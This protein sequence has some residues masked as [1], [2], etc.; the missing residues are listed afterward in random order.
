MG[1]RAIRYVNE[2][3]IVGIVL[4]GHPYHLDPEVNHGI[5]ELINGY[6]VAVLTEDSVAGRMSAAN[7]GDEI[8]VIDQWAYHSRL[9]RAAYAVAKDPDLRMIEMVQMNSFGCGLDAISAD[10]AAKILEK[11]GRLHTLLKIDESKNNGAVRIRIRSLLAAVKAENSLPPE[12]PVALKAR[13]SSGKRTILCPPLSQYHF[14]FLESIMRAEGYD[15]RVLPEGGRESAELGL[16]YVNNDACYPAMIVVGQFLNALRSGEYDPKN[17]DCFYAQTGGSCRA[18]NYVPLLRRALD[19]AGFEEARVLAVNSQGKNSVSFRLPPRVI[20]RSAKA[21]V[22]G[23]LLMRLL[24]RTRPYEL[25]PGEATE[26]YNAWSSRYRDMIMSGSAMSFRSFVCET[27]ADF[28]RIRVTETEKPKVG[29]V[30]EILVKYHSGANDRLVDLI[31]SSGGEAVLTDIASFLLYCLFDPVYRY[32]SLSGSFCSAVAGK[33]SIAAVEMIRKPVRDALRGTRFGCL[34]DIYSLSDKASSVVSC[35]N[36]AGEGWLLTAEMI[37]LIESGVKKI[38]CVQPFA[39]LPNH[40]TGKGVIKEL[41]R[42]YS[43][44]SLLALDYDSGTSS[45]NQMNRIRLLMS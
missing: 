40:I 15:F 13:H 6:N 38:I 1:E 14:Q 31:E 20:F 12:I 33:A 36:Q 35:A 5:P 24:L 29:I 16:N 23:D 19:D 41:R 27:V 25:R 45:V 34:H 21:M 8:K 17:T 37:S 42:R 28:N 26:V 2:K 44:T 30:G 39:C 9:Y 7:T 10:Q 11:E 32:R 3:G 22:Y 18:S 43:G 4:A